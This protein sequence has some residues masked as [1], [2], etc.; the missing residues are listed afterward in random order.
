MP[1]LI[2]LPQLAHPPEHAILDLGIVR[3]S[4]TMTV[5][6]S[7]KL[8]KKKLKKRKNPTKLQAAVFQSVYEIY[9]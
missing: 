3:L 1:S 8:K 7:Y 6:I 4:P 2:P 9:P 5:E